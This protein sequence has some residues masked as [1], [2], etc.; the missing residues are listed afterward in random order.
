MER[1][2]QTQPETEPDSQREQQNIDGDKH[3]PAALDGSRTNPPAIPGKT[4]V[5]EVHLRNA[6]VK[7]T[8][9]R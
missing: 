6:T 9:T 7:G 2:G 3:S 4:T 8:A 5:A 1:T